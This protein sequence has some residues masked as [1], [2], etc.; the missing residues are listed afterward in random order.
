MLTFPHDMEE[1]E[2]RRSINEATQSN[3]SR[4]KEGE[5]LLM[6]DVCAGDSTSKLPKAFN[7]I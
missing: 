4:R 2:C 7:S 5:L 3:K 1:W 6:W